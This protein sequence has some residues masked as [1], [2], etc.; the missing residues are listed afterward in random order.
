MTRGS[1]GPM[2][3]WP[4]IT[5]AWSTRPGRGSLG[6]RRRSSGRCR[7]SGTRS[8]G[9]GSSPRLAQM[10]AEAARWSAQVAGQ[11]S[12]RP[13]D[14][15]APAAV[16]AAAEKQ[17]AGAAAEG[18]VR[19]GGV[20]AVQ[21][22]PR[23]PRQGRPEPVLGAV[24]AIGQTLDA[25]STATMVQLFCGGDLVKTHVRKPQGKQ[26][27]LADYPPE[28]IAFHMRTPAWCR[29]QAAE[30]GPACA[31]LIG[32][33][34]DGQRALPAARRPGRAAPGR[35]APA[36]PARGR[37]REGRRRRGP[38]L[39]DRQGHPRRRHRGH[40]RPQRPPG[41]AAP[42]RSCTA[43]APCSPQNPRSGQRGR[44]APCVPAPGAAS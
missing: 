11:R 16:F 40:A 26:T 36:R 21:G 24:E 4:R 8:G 35:Q 39:P 27:D 6:T 33:L 28:K 43:P 22:R 20:V 12:C 10:Q 2:P 29:K 31:A 9:A 25:R 1:T 7:I 19:A 15:A 34:L 38:V 13:L 41:T 30:I 23:H 18:P 14:G 42:P 32:G 17:R 3:S 5:A 44:A 37:L